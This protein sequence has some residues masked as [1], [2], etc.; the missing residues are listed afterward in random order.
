MNTTHQVA[1]DDEE[2]RS[3]WEQEWHQGYAA[4][5]PT[6]DAQMTPSQFQTAAASV[7]QPMADKDSPSEEDGGGFGSESASAL[8]LDALT[9]KRA[10]A[11]AKHVMRYP[12]SSL[13]RSLA[14]L[15]RGV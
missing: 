10:S 5:P 9:Q 12:P 2:L 8:S 3:A 11:P 6:L 15:L 1:E 14:P 13:P 7:A 4:P